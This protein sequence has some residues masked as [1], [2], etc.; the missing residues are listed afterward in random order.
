MLGSLR[1]FLALFVVVAHLTG[2]VQ[3]FSHWGGFAVFGFYIVS[4]Y[5]IT[6]ILNETYHFRLSKF[7]LNR[8]LRLFPIYYIV[9]VVT[10]LIIAFAS[11]AS[12]FHPA[13]KIQTRWVDI[14][15]NSLII[16]FEF[17]DATFRIVPPAWSIA[18]ELINYF[19]LWAIG[20]RN[21]TLAILVFFA[22]LTY[23]LGSFISGAGWGQRYSPFYAAILPFS[24]GAMF[25]F[26]RSS[27]VALG[28]RKMLYI[29][30]IS[31]AVWLG[32][33]VLCGY[34]GGLSSKLY[35]LFFYINLISLG[36]FIYTNISP[37][38]D[39]P[40]SRWDKRLGDLAYP[41]FLT[42]WITGFVIGQVFLNG[43]QRGLVLFAVALLPIIAVSYLLS[44][45][46]DRVIEPLRSKVRS[47][48]KA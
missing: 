26:F 18:V 1:F 48:I 36:I 25:Y 2:G 23:H 20:A 5:L 3:F 38:S 39:A 35:E 32:N 43:Q 45:I 7:A 8:F 34:M 41:V 15:G 6:L 44:E 29:S 27:V 47:G 17:Y 13:W 11:N 42:H 21:R 30:R 22:A 4:G 10:I 16:P 31:C 40:S 37:S 12:A 19:I 46:T 14:I 9:T 28:P 24:L 33:L